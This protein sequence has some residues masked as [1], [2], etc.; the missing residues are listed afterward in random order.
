MSKT[1]TY[2]GAKFAG[3]VTFSDPLTLDQEAAF[4]IANGAYKEAQLRAG[5]PGA[6]TS[7]RAFLPAILACVEKWQLA[8]IPESVTIETWPLRPRAAMIELLAFLIGEIGKLYADSTD[9]TVPN[10]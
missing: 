2:K 4:E 9:T 1:V 7:A 10:A 6:A 3:S 8:G 5:T